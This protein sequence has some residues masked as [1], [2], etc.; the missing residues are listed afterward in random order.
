MLKSIPKIRKE[1]FDT[2]LKEYYL[3]E[4]PV[5]VEGMTEGWETKEKWNLDYF[6]NNYK[7]TVVPVAYYHIERPEYSKREREY[8][9]LGDVIK[10][11]ESHQEK[12]DL[13]TDNETIRK[14][15]YV[16]GWDIES[17]NPELLDQINMDEPHFIKNWIDRLPKSVRLPHTDLFIGSSYSSTPL[18]TDSFF[19][20]PM[21]T[22]ILGKKKI[23]IISHEFTNLV[24]NGMDIFDEEIA[25]KIINEGGEIF[26]CE[27]E[28][29]DMISFPPGWW[30]AVKNDGITIA[31][32]NLHIDNYRFP[33]FEKEIRS[34]YEPTLNKLKNLAAEATC[35]MG[36][37]GPS[38]FSSY[39]ASGFKGK[40]VSRH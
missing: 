20:N 13:G 34:M 27:L 6:R 14:H 15:C 10:N 40:K 4:I 1:E 22:V 39:K 9:K 38:D 31:F 5:I 18:H 32:Q 30:H 28:A 12:F 3:K 33:V 37:L 21:L 23:R 16:V 7:D 29:G 26:E 24:K 25:S 19:V 11:L 36:S 8:L 2:F 35:E 17:K